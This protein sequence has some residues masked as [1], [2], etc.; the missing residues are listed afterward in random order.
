MQSTLRATID[1]LQELGFL[2]VFIPFI[3]SFII[4]YAVL[5]KTKVLG[6]ENGKSRKNL[7]SMV[8]FAVSF[9]FIASVV[10][11]HDLTLYLQILGMAL[12]FVISVLFAFAAFQQNT[13]FESKNIFYGAALIFVVVAFFSITGW[14]NNEKYTFITDL[15]FNPIVIIVV[16]FYV[17][18]MFITS[19][20]KKKEKG[21]DAQSQKT[22]EQLTKDGWKK[23]GES[24][25]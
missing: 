10:N 8:A 4:V 7:N 13:F 16:T 14:L 9:I 12:V 11:V 24:K 23:M 25:I 1:F 22:E 19:G 18:V 5:E 15:I 20:E 2:N 21:G 17:I 3:F 6:M